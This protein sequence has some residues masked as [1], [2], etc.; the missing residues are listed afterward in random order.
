VTVAVSCAGR[1][2]TTDLHVGHLPRTMFTVRRLINAFDYI[3]A[4]LASRQ[5][6]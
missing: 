1:K 6:T 4:L 2:F 3:S 5:C